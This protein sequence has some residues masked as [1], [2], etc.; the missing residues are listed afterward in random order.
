ML[1]KNDNYYCSKMTFLFPALISAKQLIIYLFAKDV[2][3]PKEHRVGE[4]EFYLN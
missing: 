3:G 4:S 1:P 2:V